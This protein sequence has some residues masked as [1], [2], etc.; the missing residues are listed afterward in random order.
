[1][2]LYLIFYLIWFKILE[3]RVLSPAEYWYTEIE[4]DKLLPFCEYFI[5]PYVSWYFYVG[6][7]VVY[8]LLKDKEEFLRLCCFLFVGMTVCL[9]IYTI[10]PNGQGLRPTE[11]TDDNI[12]IRAVRFLYYIDTPTNVWPSIHVLNSL[13]IHIAVMKSKHFTNKKWIRNISWIIL[14]LICISTLCLKQHS[15]IDVLA[16]CICAIPLYFL[17]YRCDFNR[18][19]TTIK[20]KIKNKS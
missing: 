3:W 5:V 10:Y 12:F 7:T 2:L 6:I 11:F 9:I 18:L 16:S 20:I 4:L 15:I 14:A 17:S 8:L 1:M 13:G 19:I